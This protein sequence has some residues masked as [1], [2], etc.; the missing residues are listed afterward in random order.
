MLDIRILSQR[1]QTNTVP[2]KVMAILTDK[3]MLFLK[4]HN[5]LE[6]SGMVISM[7]SQVQ[8]AVSI[9]RIN[10]NLKYTGF[11]WFF[12]ISCIMHD[13]EKVLAWQVIRVKVKILSM[14]TRTVRVQVYI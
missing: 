11:Q 14:I 10:S 2:W 1:N 3:A 5:S 7:K 12:E 13:G 8:F 9:F 4:V 6:V